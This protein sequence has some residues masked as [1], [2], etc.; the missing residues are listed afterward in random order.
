VIVGWC[1]QLLTPA[2]YGL[3]KAQLR[4]RQE[5][6]WKRV[7]WSLARRPQLHELELLH[8]RLLAI[9]PKVGAPPR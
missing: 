4:A 8:A 9:N 3:V 2:E 5:G 7:A 1:V 6:G